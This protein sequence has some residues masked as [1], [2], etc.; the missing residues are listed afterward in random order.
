M[1][2]YFDTSAVVP[3]LVEEPGSNRA[4]A[5]WDEAD[6]V[7]SARLLYPEARAALAQA[8]RQDRLDAPG[9]RAAV[10]G[11]ERLV[12]LLDMIE[13]TETL[14]RRAGELA[15]SHSLRGYDAIPVATAELLHDPNLVVAAGDVALLDACEALGIAVARTS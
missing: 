7:T 4:A 14:A 6:R 10:D 1:I 13:I 5:V 8:R 15:V 2:A 3:L 11:L 12:G 9:L